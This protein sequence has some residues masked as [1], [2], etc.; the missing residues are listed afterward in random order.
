M[1]AKR[2]QHRGG[3]GGVDQRREEPLVAD[4]V[5]AG[6]DLITISSEKLIGG[7]QGGIVLGKAERL[8]KPPFACEYFTISCAIVPL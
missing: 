2:A 7:P 3:A 8:K 1:L 4:S 5:K 6:A